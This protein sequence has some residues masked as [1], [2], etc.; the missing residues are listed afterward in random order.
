MQFVFAG[1]A[2]PKDEPGKRFIQDVYRFSRMPEFEGRIVFIEDYDHYVGRRLYQGVDLWLNNPRRPLEASG[3]SGMKLP[4]SGGLNLSVL[5]GWWCEAHTGKNGWAIG[6]EIPESTIPPEPA[7]E[8]E[9]DVHS[10]FHVLETQILPLYYA[11]PDG[12][13]PIAWIN[14]M[15]ESIRTIV[16]V[17][18]THR[19]VKEYTER[20]YAPA[21]AAHATLV[22]DS[23]TKSVELARWKDKIRR[24]WPHVKLSEVVIHT[25]NG[26]NVTVGD[27]VEVSV[28]TSLGPIAPE[29]VRVQALIGE[30]SNGAISQPVTIDLKQ[31][32]KLG[33]GAFRF[34]G[35]IPARESGSYGLSVRVIPTHPN[36]TQ[37]HELRLITWAH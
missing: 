29:F 5:D 31:V 8:D 14:L 24:E 13:L 23:C 33:N 27:K 3:T 26:T 19:M 35:A 6:P 10:L 37:E 1:K 17:F 22:A 36:L 7:Y 20:L 18:N 9:V 12:R 25:G 2:H 34:A 30:A 28:R 4:P 15:R 11:K 32:E 21:A 16:P